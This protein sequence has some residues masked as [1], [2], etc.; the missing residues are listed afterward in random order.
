MQPI[1][2]RTRMNR[3]NANSIAASANA[4]LR[5]TFSLPADHIDKSTLS[6]DTQYNLSAQWNNVPFQRRN[7]SSF[8]PPRNS[9]ALPPTSNRFALLTETIDDDELP[10]DTILGVDH[11]LPTMFIACPVLDHENGQ[12][13]Q[14]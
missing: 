2:Y 11:A 6:R 4:A 14:L 3:D 10:T 7:Q 5:V 12:L 13:S 8:Q 1:A 9:V